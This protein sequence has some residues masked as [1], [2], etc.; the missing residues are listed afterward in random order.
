MGS[1]KSYLVYFLTYKK[2]RKIEDYAMFT[3]YPVIVSI[4]ILKESSIAI[5]VIQSEIKIVHR[6]ILIVFR[7]WQCI[8]FG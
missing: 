7:A 1:S 5:W 4:I 8:E 3:N 2:L 6:N